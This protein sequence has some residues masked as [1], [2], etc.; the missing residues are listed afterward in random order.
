LIVSHICFATPGVV[1]M[2]DGR[3]TVYGGSELRA[4]R[5]ASGLAERGHTISLISFESYELPA[6]VVGAVRLIRQPALKLRRSRFFR[7]R[8]TSAFGDYE[9]AWEYA[10]ADV[11]IVFGVA[12]YSAMLASW[13]QRKGRPLVLLS[14][15]DLD[16]S[17]EYR[18]D[19]TALNA[20]GSR[21]NLCYDAV[22]MATAIVVQSKKQGHLARERFGR[23]TTLIANPIELPFSEVDPAARRNILWV[24]KSDAIKR[25][26]L[27][28]A[29]ARLCPDVP[30]RLIV[31][32]VGDGA[33][34]RLLAQAPANVTI[35]DCVRPADMHREYSTALALLNTSLLEGFPN[36]VLEAGSFGVPLLSLSVDPGEIISREGGGALADGDIATLAALVRRYHA[37]PVL[38]QAA[39]QRLQAY[40]RQHHEASTRIA[41]LAAVVGD[42]MRRP[43]QRIA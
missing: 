14:G 18:P 40:V 26:D 28:F 19:N 15:S 11:Y 25:P 32:R 23:H 20:Y 8:E 43:G 17:A 1:R 3:G 5:F 30:F 38:A 12:E 13:C 22:M 9:V 41:E 33:F 39:G 16:F 4:W 6:A 7:R 31:N 21:C 36:A 42:V 29:V 37:D 35:I 2:L 27:A 10:N 34:E 24:G